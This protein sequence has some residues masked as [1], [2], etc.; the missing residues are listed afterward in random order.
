MLV[1]SGAAC[2][3]EAAGPQEALAGIRAAAARLATDGL[4]VKWLGGFA[5]CG[6][7]APSGAW[8]GF[9]AAWFFLPETL[10]EMDGASASLVAAATDS[11]ALAG[12][13]DAAEATLA[14]AGPPARP[15]G[16]ASATDGPSPGP[17]VART[18]EA[19]DSG[20]VQKAVVSGSRTL[21][22][23]EAVTPAAALVAIAARE[24]SGFHYLVRPPGGPAWVGASPERLVAV[25]GDGVRA[26]ALAGT[27]RRGAHAAEDAARAKALIGSPKEREEHA[28]VVE[29]ILVRL[30]GCDPLAPAAPTV[31][32]LERMFHLQSD[33][34]GTRPDGASVLDLAARLHPTAALGGTPRA[35]ALDLIRELEPEGRGWFGGA[36]GWAT[37]D[38]QGDLTVAI[39]G[40]LIRDKEVTGFAGAGVVADSTPEAEA[41]EIALKLDSVLGAFAD[42]PA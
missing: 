32:R 16:C 20:R 1:A 38:G 15:S 10:L 23:V 22:T 28:L 6:D 9:P 3:V 4:G 25:H 7:P 11:E 24:P 33:V 8:A 21:E 5:F 13:L 36:V 39:R 41:A 2:S 17:L 19:I 12:L 26:M 42:A 34:A 31:R 37:G 30:D 18:L 14:A 29:D 40:A 35:A 27:I